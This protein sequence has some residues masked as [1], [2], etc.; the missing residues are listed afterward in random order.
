MHINTHLSD[1]LRFDVSTYPTSFMRL[2]K[3]KDYTYKVMDDR[4][5]L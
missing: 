2:V 1:R 4:N 3:T 5:V